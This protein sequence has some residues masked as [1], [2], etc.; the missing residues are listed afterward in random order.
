MTLTFPGG[1]YFSSIYNRINLEGGKYL[2][3]VNSYKLYR[4]KLIAIQV[5]MKC[6]KCCKFDK[7]FDKGPIQQKVNTLLIAPQ[8]EEG[9]F[10]ITIMCQPRAITHSSWFFLLIMYSWELFVCLT[11]NEVSAPSTRKK[12]ILYIYIYIYIVMCGYLQHVLSSCLL[13]IINKVITCEFCINYSN[14]FHK[15]SSFCISYLYHWS[16]CVSWTTWCLT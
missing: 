14:L 8:L 9:Y 4:K 13:M 11:T 5:S 3:V 2:M 6:H 16:N 1:F 15:A 7:D 10:S 12:I